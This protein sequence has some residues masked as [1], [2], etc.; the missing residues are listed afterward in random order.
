MVTRIEVVHEARSWLGTPFHHQG[1]LK[2]TGVDCAGVIVGV[3]SALEI[4]TVD[5]QGYGHRPDTRQLEQLCHAH[6]TEV[7]LEDALPGDVLLITIDHAPQHMAFM[8]DIGMLHAYAQRR[9]VVE[10]IIDQD[11]TEKIT[12][13]FKIPGIE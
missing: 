12:A 3:L 8:T 11:W 6:L 13:V 1:R 10:H 7:G 5:V 4:S 2:G 9:K